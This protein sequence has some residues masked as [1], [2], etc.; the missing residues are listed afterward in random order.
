MRPIVLLVLAWAFL[1]LL[2]ACRKNSHHSGDTPPVPNVFV[3][4]VQ[5]NDALLWKNGNPLKI[6]SQPDY[7]NYGFNS[8]SLAVS[9]GNVYISGTK[10]GLR[11]SIQTGKPIYWYN[12][13][14]Q[15]LNNPSGDAFGSAI[16]V[17]GADIYVAGFTQYPD[18]SHVPY[19]TPTA[20]YPKAGSMATV[21]K[22][23]MPVELAGVGVLGMVDSGRYCVRGYEDALSS[24]YVSG[25]DVYA[26]GG[27]LYTIAHA[28]YWKNGVRID[29]PGAT[30]TTSSIYVSGSDVY[31][32]GWEDTRL[33]TFRAVYW[34]NG[35]LHSL[36]IDSFYNSVA[37]SVVV[38]NGD[39]Y[40][41]GWQNING[42]SRAMLWK[43][44]VGTPLTSGATAS[45][46]NSVYVLGN[47]VY[48]AGS[49]W[50][51]QGSYVAVYWKNGIPVTL[52]DGTVGASA[53]AIR[54]E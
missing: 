33:N 2:P 1:L 31:V 41:A 53:F 8:S 19:S 50:V 35:I 25:S 14:V 6:D 7:V 10:K 15:T 36:S 43:N 39:V 38:A 22:N 52:T 11:G 12:G 34:K 21:W 9:N 4:G 3:L 46:A 29:L 48:V 49:Q 24:I 44:G 20:N 51:V 28:A 37:A 54:V 42:Y 32:A 13:I 30:P 47:D 18:T 5:G 40:I 27:S 26:S 45:A 17:S 23:G 16:F